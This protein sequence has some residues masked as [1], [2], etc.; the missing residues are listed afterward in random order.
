MSPA[1]VGNC[2]ET[3]PRIWYSVSMG[4]CLSFDYSGCDGYDIK[5]I[6]IK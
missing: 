3:I 4:K 6:V 5:K 1:Q 2:D